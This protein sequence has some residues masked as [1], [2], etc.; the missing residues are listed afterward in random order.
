L[1]LPALLLLILGLGRV[2]AGTATLISTGPKQRYTEDIPV[3]DIRAFGYRPVHVPA[4]DLS[5][6]A[7]ELPN[8]KQSRGSD[9][10]NPYAVIRQNGPSFGQTGARVRYEITLANYESISHT[11]QLMDRLPA[12]LAFVPG[13]AIDLTYDPRTRSLSWHGSLAPGNLDYLIEDSPIALPYLDLSD[14]GAVNLCDAFIAGGEDCD[15]ASITFNL[16]INGY[17]TNLYGEVLSQLAVS[18]NGLVLSNSKELGDT[19]QWLPDGNAPNFL[20]AGLWRDADLTQSGRWHAAIIRGLV[21]GHDV[22]YAQWHDA[23]HENDFN[24]TARYAIAVVLERDGNLTDQPLVGHAF[25]L[26][27]N[28]SD[29]AQT[30]AQGYT[31][32]IEDKLGQRG[33]TFAYG[34]C[35]G[36]LRAPQ[37]YPPASGT[38]LHLR[39]ALFGADNSYSRTLSFEAIVNGQVPE[40][41][42]NTVTAS[43]N[44]MNP[45]LADVW[46]THY[47]YVRLQ[48]YLPFLRIGWGIP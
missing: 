10:A 16:G 33:A 46:A 14:F 5:P 19:N 38:T 6:L 47:L 31:I 39:S 1:T 35:C 42:V 25:Y 32:G 4:P 34:P 43:S 2:E 21:E 48:T 7:P 9:P 3:I 29:P 41:I 40:T 13:S 24:L 28:I 37:G 15:D 8:L 45:E 11:Y 12:G 27:D 30:V 23:P 17:T 22:F 20:L 36:E 26:Y 18:S 44:S